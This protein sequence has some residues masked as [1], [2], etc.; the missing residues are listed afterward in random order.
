MSNLDGLWQVG[1]P[2]T[3]VFEIGEPNAQTILKNYSM[4]HGVDPESVLG[5]FRSI[6]MRPMQ[7]LYAFVLWVETNPRGSFADFL[8][9]KIRAVIPH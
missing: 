3:R 8:D 7:A 6:R 9:E 4:C 2:A 5:F 1:L